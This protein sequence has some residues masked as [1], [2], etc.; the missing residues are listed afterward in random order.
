MYG[1]EIAKFVPPRVAEDVRARVGKLGIKK[2]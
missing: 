2:Q 1:G